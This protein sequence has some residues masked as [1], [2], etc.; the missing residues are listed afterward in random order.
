ML[1]NVYRDFFPYL[2]KGLLNKFSNKQLETMK[3]IKAQLIVTDINDVLRT[4]KLC[5]LILS[6]FTCSD[7]TIIE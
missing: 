3:E 2:M 1:L 6:E 7:D 4:D 5:E